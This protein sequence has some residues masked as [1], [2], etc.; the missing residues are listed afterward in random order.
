MGGEREDIY[1]MGIC[2]GSRKEWKN[3][4]EVRPWREAVPSSLPPSLP[5]MAFFFCFYKMRIILPTI[6]WLI[7]AALDPVRFNLLSCFS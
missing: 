7:L 2:R 6:H 5:P 3:E 1:D 4:E